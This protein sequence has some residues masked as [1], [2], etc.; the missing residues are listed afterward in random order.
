MAITN[1]PSIAD[2]LEQAARSGLEREWVLEGFETVGS[3]GV[4]NLVFE[5]VS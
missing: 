1:S 3:E 2:A 4:A 5:T